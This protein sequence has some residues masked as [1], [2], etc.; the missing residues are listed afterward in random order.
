VN[1]I[2]E[3]ME[4]DIGI[5]GGKEGGLLFKRGKIVGKVKESE[6][7]DV[8][9]AEVEAMAKEREERKE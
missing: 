3:G 2:G 7:A 8:L 1:G 4:A 5:A 6:M 9:V